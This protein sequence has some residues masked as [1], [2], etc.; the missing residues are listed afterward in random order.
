MMDSKILIT[1]F[2]KNQLKLFQFR[3]KVLFCFEIILTEIKNYSID[4]YFKLN[5]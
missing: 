3:R 5:I 2:D 4:Q 1:F